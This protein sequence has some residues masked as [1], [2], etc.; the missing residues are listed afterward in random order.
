MT[1]SAGYLTTDDGLR[2]FYRTLGT[3][4]RML[5]VP[6]AIHTY[7]DFRGLA[8]HRSV[9]FYDLRNR[10]QSETVTDATKLAGGIVSDVEDL[11]A[12]RRHIGCERCDV[13]GWSYVGMMAVLYA[14][15]HP[16]NVG[17]VVQI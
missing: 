15:R 6:N 1:T 11:D 4:S 12:V 10:G 3:G 7:V 17:R 8:A 13:I 16:R 5:I 9:V 14:E 2:L